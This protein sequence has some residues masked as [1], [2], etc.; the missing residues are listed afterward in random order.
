VILGDVVERNGLLYPSHE[1]VIDENGRMTFAELADRTTRLANVLVGR[2][3]RRGD[4]VAVLSPN[5]HELVE[6]FGA[7]EM[8]GFITVPLNVRQTRHELAAVL[9]DCA[10]SVLIFDRSFAS[11]VEQLRPGLAAKTYVSIGGGSASADDYE[12]VLASANAKRPATRA[13]PDDTAFI[14]YTSGSTGQPKGVMHGHRGQIY[15]ALSMCID[16][17][18]EATDRMLIP[19]PMYVAGGKWMQMTYH[20]RGCTIVLQ[21]EFDP[22]AVLEAIERERI[23]GV[24]LPATM[25]RAVLDHPDFSRRDLSSLRVVYYAASPTPE[26]LLRRALK[27]FGP[28]LVQYYG[29]TEGGGV[30]TTMLKH[31]HV[32]DGDP[33]LQQRLSSAGQAKQLSRVRIVRTDGTDCDVDEAGEIIIQSDG[34]M[35]GYWNQ[36]EATAEALKGGWL[37]TGDI[38]TRDAEHFIYVVGRKKEM[39]VSG[40]SN[41]Y[42]REVED[43]L[44]RHPAVLEAAVIGVPDERWGETVHAVVTRRPGHAVTE[45]AL[46]EHC[47]SLIASYKKPTAV[48][49]MDRLP[50][51]ESGKIDKI[52]LSDPFWAGR[53]R[54]VN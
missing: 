10:P 30:G 11:T 53:K 52:A 34:L 4:R 41:I 2:D 48:T 6:V 9:A 18:L 24:L 54:R 45:D 29:G 43:A 27:A 5:C 40:G 25:M 19:N 16:G 44:H 37:H 46:I 28:I 13:E 8:C 50:K 39:I 23:T 7:N 47:R 33:R 3:V 31:H 26:P 15:A 49:F 36:P 17:S 12:S 14:L 32:P 21:R 51:L 35:Q 20:F 38:G 42:P 1:A 22:A